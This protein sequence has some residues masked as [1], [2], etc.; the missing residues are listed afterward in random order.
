MIASIRNSCLALVLVSLA[1]GCSASTRSPLGERGIVKGKVTFDGKPVTSGSVGFFP[2]ERGQ[3]DEQYG[4]IDKS[5]QY[6]ASLFPGK[7]RVAIEPEGVRSGSAGKS[8]AVPAKFQKPDT[9]GIEVEVPS[10]GR[11]ALD[12]PLK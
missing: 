1:G 4:F 10:G 3:G 9:S 7:Y 8:S 6:T 12:F 2:V 11:E 5:G